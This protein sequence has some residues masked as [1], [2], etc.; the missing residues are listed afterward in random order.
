MTWINM[1][2]PFQWALMA[3]VP[4]MI[5][6]L[7][8]LKLR[9]QPL[10]VPSTYLWQRAVEDLHVNSI[11]QRLRHNILLLLQLLAILALCIA[12]LRPGSRGADDVGNRSIFLV[13]NSA[14]MSAT[15]VD[16]S[17][18]KEAKNKVLDLISAMKSA[19]VGMI[20]AFSDRADIKQGFTAD[21]ARLRDAVRSIQPTQ[22]ITDLNEA[23]RAAAG[24]ANP[25]RTSQMEDLND[26]QVAEA[27]PANLYILSDGCF[28]TPQLDLGNL[29]AEYLPIGTA[30]PD[31]VGIVSFTVE[32]N[33]ESDG[34]IEAFGRIQNFGEDDVIV[35]A[36]LSLGGQFI[37]AS[38]VEVAAG[39]SAGV[40]FQL[41]NI[42]EG[43]M[44]LEIDTQDDFL[45][46]NKAFAGL[47][48]PK[49]LE[50]V[51]VTA[52]NSALESAL[53]TSQAAALAQ[54]RILAPD[55]LAS[56]AAKALAE[57]GDIDLFVYD[58]CAPESMPAANTLFVGMLPP[59][60]QWSAAEPSGPL[61][62][63][64]T[65]RNHPMLQYVDMGSVRIVEGRSLTIPKGGTEL[66]RTE[67]GVLMGVAPR[68]AYQDA[69][70][71][72]PLLKRG[73]AGVI[74]NTDWPIKRSFPVFFFNSLSYLGGAVTTA[75][76]ATAKPG[77][78]VAL[79]TANRYPVLEVESPDSRT[80]TI[81]R[82]GMPQVLFTQTEES[83]FYRAKPAGEDRVLQL[84]TVNLF[85][86]RESDI[87]IAP[88][89]RIGAED[90][91][92]TDPASKIVRR[93]YWRWILLVALIVL[94]AEWLIYNRRITV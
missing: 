38:N 22:R 82:S 34:Q 36:S 12:L 94:A 32:R 76:S 78:T 48:P 20:I 5:I 13:D 51:L 72:M 57:S 35:E 79:S 9:R 14:S 16:G 23:L 10:V 54:V 8:F 77:E 24:L 47:D 91:A 29:T 93:E 66:L 33:I 74:P 15:D 64:D 55:E 60:D 26:I 49:E 31:N 7:Y 43:E 56:D 87:R 89:V 83:G 45:L 28:A 52:G 2:T 65:N 46:D 68:G 80:T 70:V 73:E 39:E 53:A 40:S 88:D 81:D 86:D 21:K 6:M 11:W 25:G 17:R 59:G 27:V 50:V 42:S 37:D 69:V 67:E 58:N 84:F 90:V 71:A 3:L 41:V 62:I 63:I 1:L 85:S 92:A 75:G 30:N 4:P 19:D 61:F 44:Q 18:L